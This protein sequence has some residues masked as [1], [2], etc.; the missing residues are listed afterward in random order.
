ME[1]P[2]G[3]CRP[4]LCKQDGI[5]KMRL[6]AIIDCYPLILALLLEK[7]Y[8]N[9]ADLILSCSNTN[10]ESGL[11]LSYFFFFREKVVLRAKIVYLQLLIKY[12]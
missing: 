8:S 7:A 2:P 3:T 11:D 5:M 1:V 6:A 4:G 12:D 10:K 9:G